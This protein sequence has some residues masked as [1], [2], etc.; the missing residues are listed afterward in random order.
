MTDIIKD[1]LDDLVVLYATGKLEPDIASDLETELQNQPDLAPQIEG[2]RF[3]NG[4]LTGKFS[5]PDDVGDDVDMAE[6]EM[7]K[8]TE[9]KEELNKPKSET[10]I[11]QT[12]TYQSSFYSLRTLGNV[13]AL[14]MFMILGY[15]IFTMIS[16]IMV[17]PEPVHKI[18][19]NDSGKMPNNKN[20]HLNKYEKGSIPT[21]A[22]Y[23][24]TAKF[25]SAAG[26]ELDILK[27][28][29][30]NAK[31][32]NALLA[33]FARENQEKQEV[34]KAVALFYEL[35]NNFDNAKAEDF[36]KV[37][38]YLTPEIIGNDEELKSFKV[39]IEKIINDKK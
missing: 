29:G 25:E 17:E 6:L 7:V 24:T 3:L 1:D 38:G 5:L 15:S 18:S 20:D 26:E 4:A 2:L 13:A 14:T 32:E 11:T 19:K 23:D 31:T 16:K 21:N 22:Q 12:N 34:K 30:V 39:V 33:T 35:I 27:K 8:P 36:E 9:E 10:L 28:Y 37:S